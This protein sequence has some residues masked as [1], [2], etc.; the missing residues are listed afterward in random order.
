MI[1][2]AIASLAILLVLIG[3]NAIVP[4]KLGLPDGFITGTWCQKVNQLPQNYH[5]MVA[6]DKIN[7]AEFCTV[8][9]FFVG[10]AKYH[11]EMEYGVTVEAK[12][13]VKIT[14]RKGLTV[15]TDETATPVQLLQPGNLMT[16][17]LLLVA[18]AYHL[19]R[20]KQ[21]P[22]KRLT[23]VR[24]KGEGCALC[25]EF[26]RLLPFLAVGLAELLFS[27]VPVE[28]GA[29]SLASHLSLAVWI[30]AVCVLVICAFYIFPLIRWRGRM[31]YDRMTG[32]K[33]VRYP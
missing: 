14:S 3:L 22:G 29:T 2:Y 17:L 12:G 1:D 23:G 5:D 8:R 18:S 33:V 26:W 25:R 11:V 6:P 31:F 13:A 10:P 32:F 16:A 9:P 19:Q 30:Y 27:F 24:I 4:N 21:T 28:T 20:G 15:P 7:S